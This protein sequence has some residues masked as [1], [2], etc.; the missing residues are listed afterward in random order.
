MKKIL[1]AS[2]LL[3]RI[4]GR[5]IPDVGIEEAIS[6]QACLEKMFHNSVFENLNG[7][8]LC[9]C[10]ISQIRAANNEWQKWLH[11][12]QESRHACIVDLNG[13]SSVII[14]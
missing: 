10:D 12:L 7:S 5:L 4:V 9:T 8:V 13:Q 11:D 1:F 3:F 14:N 6:I 2:E